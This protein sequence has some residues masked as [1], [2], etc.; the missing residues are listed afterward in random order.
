MK[1]VATSE[2]VFLGTKPQTVPKKIIISKD[3][4]K[5]KIESLKKIGH[6]WKQRIK[7]V[8]SQFP[9]SKPFVPVKNGRRAL[10]P[11]P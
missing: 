7:V 9:N 6:P 1:M 3:C 8:N 10:P 11:A 4:P 2:C 5:I